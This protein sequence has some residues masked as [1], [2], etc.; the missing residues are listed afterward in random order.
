MEFLPPPAC[1]AFGVAATTGGL[2]R[3]T[4][5]LTSQQHAGRRDEE[6][7]LWIP[8]GCIASA[9]GA[10][11]KAASGM[12]AAPLGRARPQILRSRRSSAGQLLSHPLRCRVSAVAVNGAVRVPLRRLAAGRR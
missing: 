8:L 3:V 2:G 11:G 7:P 9:R 4:P 5:P 1:T 12:P 6:M 10:H